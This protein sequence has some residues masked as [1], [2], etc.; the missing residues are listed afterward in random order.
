MSTIGASSTHVFRIFKHLGIHFSERF[1]TCTKNSTPQ[2]AVFDDEKTRKKSRTKPLSYDFPV[3]HQVLNMVCVATTHVLHLALYITIHHYRPYLIITDHHSDDSDHST[4]IVTAMTTTRYHDHHHTSSSKPTAAAAD[5]AAGAAAG[6]Q[7][8]LLSPAP[9]FQ[10]HHH[11]HDH[12][13]F[14]G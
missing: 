14:V 2:T 6:S 5:A 8:Q 4:M 10:Y 13:P 7:S 12:D 11:R 3:I 1:K 9:S